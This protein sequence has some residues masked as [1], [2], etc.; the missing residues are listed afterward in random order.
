[1]RILLD[2]N[3]LISALISEQGTPGQLLAL[4][5][6]SEHLL[7]TSPFQVQEVRSVLARPRLRPYIR[8]EQAESLL[9]TITSVGLLIHDIA[10]V[11][12]SPDPDD[13][14]ILGAA[15]AG[16]ADIVVSG[17]KRHVL[18]L[19]E[20]SGIPIMSAREALD[21]LSCG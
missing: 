13:N 5:R 17:D 19:G 6:D 14:K 11:H 21:R 7:I 18:M 9:S 20:I 1:V 10:E 3:I 12:D 16:K 8:P 2:T 4:I 15:I